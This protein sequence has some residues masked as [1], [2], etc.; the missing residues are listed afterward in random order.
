VNSLAGYVEP[1]IDRDDLSHEWRLMW[2]KLCPHCSTVVIEPQ[3]VR[4]LSGLVC[5]AC[6]QSSPEPPFQ[7]PASEKYR[8]AVSTLHDIAALGKKAG[9]EMAKHRLIMLGEYDDSGRQPAAGGG[10]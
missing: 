10:E 3:N 2:A 9:S 7:D 5:V 8:A 1:Q 4:R 6:C